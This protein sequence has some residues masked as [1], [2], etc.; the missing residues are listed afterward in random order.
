MPEKLVEIHGRYHECNLK[1]GIRCVMIAFGIVF[2][3]DIVSSFVRTVSA[4]FAIPLSMIY[5]KGKHIIIF[6]L[7]ID[8]IWNDMF[9]SLILDYQYT[10]RKG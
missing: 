9:I 2:M 6:Q 10:K 7:G 4:A 8:H 1:V 5:M 3:P